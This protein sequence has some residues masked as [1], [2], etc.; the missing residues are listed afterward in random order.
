M[1]AQLLDEIRKAEVMSITRI[2]P[3]HQI[4]IP[5]DIFKELKLE[6]GDFL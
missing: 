2:G 6:V 1:H 3:K 5:K 4:T